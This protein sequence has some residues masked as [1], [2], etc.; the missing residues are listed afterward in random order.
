MEQIKAEATHNAEAERHIAKLTEDTRDLYRQIKA[1]DSALQE[2]GIKLE[3]LQKQLD[4]SK[5]HALDIGA[6]KATLGD[7]QRA[8]KDYRAANESL[9]TELEALERANDVLKQQAAQQTVASTGAGAAQGGQAGE[10]DATGLA[11][12][13]G[14][15]LG[16]ASLEATYLVEQLEALRGVLAVVRAENCY[17]K[18]A[19]LLQQLEALPRI[20]VAPAAR[21]AA[22]DAQDGVKHTS[23]V[24]APRKTPRKDVSAIARESKALYAELLHMAATPRLVSLGPSPA[25]A[26]AA[27]AAAADAEP[28]K[29]AAARKTW[30][31]IADKPAS[32]LYAQEHER[33]RVRERIAQLAQAARAAEH[34][35][36]P[37]VPTTRFQAPRIAASIPTLPLL[38]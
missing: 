3:R 12:G 9:Q 24:P 30:Q 27:A 36:P 28:T 31:R 19:P 34:K 4:K 22:L 23:G 14:L 29:L 25:S 5:E 33:A 32:Q 13:G 21:D 17:L 7:A 20:H 35:R 2:A 1:R 26:A 16:S 6:I 18:G 38:V 15:T 10:M 37:L 8:A 11:A